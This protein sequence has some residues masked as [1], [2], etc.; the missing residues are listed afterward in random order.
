[1]KNFIKPSDCADINSLVKKAIELK[2]SSQTN[3]DIGKGKTMILLF[4]NNSLR[5]RLSTQIAAEQLGMHV[6][7]LDMS[8]AWNLEMETGAVMNFDSAEHIKD[9]A[10]VLSMYA[11]IIGVRAFAKLENKEI[12]ASDT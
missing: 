3:H 9:A 11:D 1:M 6:I 8:A 7:S 12:D 10:A 2:N 5:T 4:F